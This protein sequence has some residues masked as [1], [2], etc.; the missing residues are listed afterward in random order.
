MYECVRSVPSLQS[1]F[2]HS[3]ASVVPA[4]A[5]PDDDNM[6]ADLKAGL[7]QFL[8]H[9]TLKLVPPAR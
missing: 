6:I 3:A 1:E 2:L 5:R 7:M 4:G 8:H 9:Q